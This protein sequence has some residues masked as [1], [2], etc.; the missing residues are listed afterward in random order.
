MKI[1]YITF[2]QKYRDEEHPLGG[3]PDGFAVVH[4]ETYGIARDLTFAAI[5]IKWSGI[6]EE[7]P[8]PEWYPM[9]EL[10]TI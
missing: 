4:A 5:G 2:G 1:F 10:F 7:K 9:G 6:Y 3:H 8:N